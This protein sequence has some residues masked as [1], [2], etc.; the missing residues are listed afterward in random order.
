MG[1]IYEI[2][3]L[4]ES[5]INFD[6]SNNKIMEAHPEFLPETLETLD[7][8]DNRL[9]DIGKIDKSFPNLTT[10][11][12]TN[13]YGLRWNQYPEGTWI[14]NSFNLHRFLGENCNFHSFP[15]DLTELEFI[16][17]INL[18]NNKLNYPDLSVFDKIKETF[19]D[20]KWTDNPWKCDCPM[21]PFARYL[22]D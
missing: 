19:T 3:D 20:I 2:S 12:I 9:V 15:R 11:D 10:L 7:I 4:P 21:L 1:N 14:K 16:T 22:E 17:E 5:I 18:N 6:I 8:S 13:N